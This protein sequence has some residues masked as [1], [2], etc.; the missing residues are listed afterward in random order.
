MYD[1][2]RVVE[3]F[4]FY[5]LGNIP[6]IK[7]TIDLIEKTVNVEGN[8][9]ELGT[10]VG[11]NCAMMGYILNYHGKDKIIY[12][13]DSFEGIPYP[14]EED[15]E[16]PGDPEG[17]T[18]T[19]ELKSTGVS[20]ASLPWVLKTLKLSDYP[21]S[22][23]KIIK[24]WVQNTLPETIDKV[25]P[26]AFLRLDLDLYA[27]TKLG[28]EYMYDKVVKGGYVF[29]HDYTILAGC[30]QAVDEF[31]EQHPEINPVVTVEGGGIYWVKG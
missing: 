11:G 17:V 12:M 22:N 8:Y 25:K 2:D 3:D 29:V 30:K 4:R 18:R 14:T 1:I 24:G 20:V 26:L 9:C 15:K 21:L 16:I 13:Y 19:G 23:F 7:Q 6:H 31:L 27:P 5:I 28:L 10:F